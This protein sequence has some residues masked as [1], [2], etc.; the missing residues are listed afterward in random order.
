MRVASLGE[1]LWDLIGG[2]E[3][4]G[5][6]TF[7]FS[8]Q[9]SRLG[10]DVSF[11]SAV[12]DDERGRRAIDAA[13]RLGLSTKFIRTSKEAPTGTVS[14]F[15]DAQRQP[16]YVLHRP[17]AYDFAAMLNEPIRPEWI[18]HGTLQ[19]IEPRMLALLRDLISLYPDARRFYDINLR[20]DS[21]SGPLVLELLALADVVKLNDDELFTCKGWRGRR[22]HQSKL[23]ARIMHRDSS[24]MRFA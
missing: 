6:A 13:K 17:A 2:E 12:G 22:T 8:V 1:I 5:G 11:I 24:G 7:N 3:F 20:K 14:V 16:R 19:L 15:L 23:S 18:Y 4:L 21:Y 9:L 10:H